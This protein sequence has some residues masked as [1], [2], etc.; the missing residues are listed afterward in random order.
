MGKYTKMRVLEHK[1]VYM[2][3]RTNTTKVNKKWYM[4]KEAVDL[5]ADLTAD[6]ERCTKQPAQIADK[7]AKS[8][9]NQQKENQSTAETATQNTK[10]FS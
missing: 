8:H 6:Q 3:N 10:S 2:T 4:E 5:T 9:S 1:S 7:N